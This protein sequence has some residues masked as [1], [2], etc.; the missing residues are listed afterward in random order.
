MV[1]KAA[2]FVASIRPRLERVIAHNAGMRKYTFLNAADPYHAYYQ[3]RLY[4][5]LEERLAVGNSVVV[6]PITGELNTVNDMSQHL[7][8]PK[9]KEQR[10]RLYAKFRETTLAQD[11]EISTIKEDIAITN[12]VLI[13]GG[14]EEPEPKRQ[15]LDESL[16]VPEDQFLAQHPG[17][18][19]IIVWVP[20]KEQLLEISVESLSES[21]SSFKEKIAGEIE[22]VPPANKQKLSGTARLF[23]DNLSLA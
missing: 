4:E 3:H 8:D 12:H 19:C 11:D 13:F 7:R 20:D 9:Y 18:A 14:P 5:R 23:K 2:R 16:L 22:E 21:V 17:P 1:D 15:R 6:S 10:E